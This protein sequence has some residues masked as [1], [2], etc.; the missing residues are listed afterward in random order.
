MK[1]L[2]NTIIKYHKIKQI[3]FLCLKQDIDL[4]LDEY[5]FY[6]INKLLFHILWYVPLLIEAIKPKCFNNKMAIKNIHF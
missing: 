2:L 5:N 3:S 6:I 4:D 1:I